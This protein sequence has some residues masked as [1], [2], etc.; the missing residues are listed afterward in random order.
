MMDALRCTGVI[1][2]LLGLHASLILA[3]PRA[4]AELGRGR[5]K[6]RAQTVMV[7]SSRRSHLRRKTGFPASDPSSRNLAVGLITFQA[8]ATVTGGTIYRPHESV[9]SQKKAPFI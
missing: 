3:E 8:I 4:K 6:I 7:A 9:P 5:T 2:V 1:L